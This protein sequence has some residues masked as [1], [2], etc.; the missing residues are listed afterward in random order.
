[1]LPDIS[2]NKQR[3]AIAVDKSTYL[4]SKHLTNLTH[5]RAWYCDIHLILKHIKIISH[6]YDI[7]LRR[8]RTIIRSCIATSY[9]NLP[10]DNSLVILTTM[11]L[12]EN[13][14]LSVLYFSVNCNKA[15][16]FNEN[17]S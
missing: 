9:I 2:N 11:N 13:K 4:G 1:M 6:N 10:Y 16:A 14:R 17:K 5:L 8:G 3:N 7:Y 15:V 12:K